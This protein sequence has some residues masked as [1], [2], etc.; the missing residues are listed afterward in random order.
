MKNTSYAHKTVLITGASSGIGEAFGHLLAQERANLILTARPE[1]KLQQLAKKLRQAH[2]IQVHVFPAD[3]SQIEA[4]QQLIQQIQSA[5][6][7]VDLLINNAGFGKWTYFDQLPLSVF[8]EMVSL[9]IQG[10]MALSYLCH[11]CHNCWPKKR[12]GLSM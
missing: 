12:A 4:P 6:L 1:A 10:L 2:S 5:G 3:L 9:N 8:Q 7:S 11:A